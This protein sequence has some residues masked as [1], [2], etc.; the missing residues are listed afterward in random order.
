MAL[1][2]A[3]WEFIV[4]DVLLD[5]ILEFSRVSACPWV[6]LERRGVDRAALLQVLSALLCVSKLTRKTAALTVQ[7]A[8]LRLASYDAQLAVGKIPASMKKEYALQH[9]DNHVALF[10]KSWVLYEALPDHLRTSPLHELRLGDLHRLRL[11]LGA[12][13]HQEIQARRGDGLSNSPGVWVTP[14]MRT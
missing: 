4:N 14:A 5:Y 1:K 3:D 11:V 9:F 13:W 7:Y 6:A 12:G 8:A 10:S 2:T